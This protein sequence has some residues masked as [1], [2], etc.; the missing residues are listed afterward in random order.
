MSVLGALA[1]SLLVTGLGC[2]PASRTGMSPQETRLLAQ[3]AA[4]T[5]ASREKTAQ[6]ARK[7][8]DKLAKDPSYLNRMNADERK[9]LTVLAA[10]KSGSLDEDT[11]R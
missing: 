6:D 3:T 10:V 4:A 9:L 11:E 1:G 8:L 7:L 5:G 2:Q